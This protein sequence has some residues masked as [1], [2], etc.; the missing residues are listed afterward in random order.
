MLTIQKQPLFGTHENTA[1]EMARMVEQYAYQLPGIK[2]VTAKQWYNKIKALPYKRDPKGMEWVTNPLITINPNYK[3]FRDCDD[4]AI[5]MAAWAFVHKKPYRFVAGAK[6]GCNLH[7]VWPEIAIN[8]KNF[9]SF[10]AT[11]PKKYYINNNGIWNYKKVLY[12]YLGTLEGD[13]LEGF[14]EIAEKALQN[15][16]VISFLKRKGNDAKNKATSFVKRKLGLKKKAAV[17]K[18]ALAPNK[19]EQLK[20]VT[21]IPQQR[22]ATSMPAWILPAAAV[23]AGLYF[24]KK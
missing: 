24:L 9:I 7:H 13:K 10:D 5:L 14:S 8:N 21:V 17:K 16:A 6:K 1:S 20:N 4:K 15:P 23:G 3:G 11:F 22:P 18:K 2:Q 19:K 12:M